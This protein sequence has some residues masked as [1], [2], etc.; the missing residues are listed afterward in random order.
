MHGPAP[1][2]SALERRQRVHQAV[3]ELMGELGYRVS[4]EAVAQRAGCAKQTLYSDYGSK[5]ELLRSMMQEH[6][7]LASAPLDSTTRGVHET[8]LVFAEEHLAR[9]SDPSVVAACHLLAAQS[10]QYPEEAQALYRDGC[11]AMQERLALWLQAAMARGDLRHDD[12]HL[13][14]ELLMSMIGGLDM[15]RQRLAVSHRDSNPGRRAWL[16][17]AIGNFM[18]AFAPSDPPSAAEV[19]RPRSRK[20]STT[21]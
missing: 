15:E 20:T 10:Q 6:L 8:L 1:S 11:Q 2:P 9:L 3:R 18:R 17:F 13:A 21:S 4:M 5:Q 16:E 19:P 12:P 14:A 7:E